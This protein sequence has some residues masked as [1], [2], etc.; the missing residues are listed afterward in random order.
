MARHVLLN[1]TVAKGRKYRA[2]T[3]IDDAQDQ[4]A[5]AALEGGGGRFVTL[6]DPAIEEAA[7]IAQQRRLS[8]AG[9][10]ELDAIMLAAA[11]TRPRA[12]GEMY[13]GTPAATTPA[14]KETYLKALGTTLAGDLYLFDMPTDNRLRYLGGETARFGIDAI[15]SMSGAANDNLRFVIAKNGSDLIKTVQR[16]KVGAGGDEGN[17]SCGGVVELATG[18]YVELWVANWTDVDPFT[19]DEL[20]MTAV[21]V[22]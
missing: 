16:R 1:T 20:N 15:I 19:V 2:G 17:A 13:M 12:H 5:K 10:V 21:R 7:T 6:P 4:G 9:S 18:E 11:V 3:V 14:L 22:R 8:G